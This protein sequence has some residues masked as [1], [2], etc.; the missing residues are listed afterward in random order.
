MASVERRAA[1]YVGF[2]AVLIVA[3]SFLYDYGMR[4]IEPGPYP[5]SVLHSVQVVVETFT[6]TG[7]GSDSPWSSAELNL[8]IILLDLTGVALFFVALPAVVLP[9]FRQALS[10]SPPTTVDEAVTGHVVVCSYT[11]RA[12]ALIGELE[13]YDVEYVLVEPQRERAADLQEEGYRVAHADPESVSDLEDVN[14]SDARTLVADVSDQVDAS[15]VLA[16]RE[17]AEDVPVVSVVEEPDK[18][19]YHRL[20]G[21]DAVLLPRQLLGRGLAQKLTTAVT[22]DLGDAIHVGED[23]DLAEFPIHHGSELV[24]STL[25]DSE[26]RERYGVNV[27]GAWF[28]GEFESPPPPDATLESSTVLLVSGREEQLAALKEKT[29]ATVRSFRQGEI[30][31]VGYGE[32]GRTIADALDDHDLSYTVVDRDDRENVDVV[33]EATDPD[34]LRAA[35]VE[36]AQSVVLA[37]PDDTST[38][39]ATLVVRDLNDSAEILARADSIEDVKKTYRAGAD[40]VLSLATVTGRSIASAVLEREQ[41]LS[42]GTSVEVIRTTAPGLTGTTLENA[43]VRERTGCTIIAVERT[44]HVIT[45]LGPEFAVETDDELVIAGTDEGTNAFLELFG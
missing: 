32:V 26:I 20:A 3:S 42:P 6:A 11:S 22:T 5:Y 30:V 16:A 19:S 1:Y 14:L 21:A 23:F 24:G 36:E 4:T 41:V 10:T 37:V 15:I 44:G 27:V 18:E 8:L 34:V 33:G 28:Q 43:R 39:F 29:T 13:S 38:E 40:Y 35:G 17:V 12:E 45:D 9:L 2:I 7:Y 25:A 31:L